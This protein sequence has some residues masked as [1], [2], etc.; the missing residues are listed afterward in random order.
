MFSKDRLQLANC[1]LCQLLATLVG[2]VELDRFLRCD[3]LVFLRLFPQFA[4]SVLQFD[5]LGPSQRVL[6]A[7]S[8]SGLSE[9]RA[10]VVPVQV[11]GAAAPSVVDVLPMGTIDRVTSP[12]ADD[13]V[14]HGIRKFQHKNS[15]VC[16]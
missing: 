6:P 3:R 1:D 14:R 16:L 2:E 5:C 4:L 7:A 10:F 8:A 12:Y 15:S 11:L 9:L 13:H